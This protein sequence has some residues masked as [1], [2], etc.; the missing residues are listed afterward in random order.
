MWISV[1]T[2]LLYSHLHFL[3][4]TLV[5]L[6]LSDNMIKDQGAEYLAIAFRNNTVN[7]SISFVSWFFPHRRLLSSTLQEI[8]LVIKAYKICLLLFE[9]TRLISLSPFF[10]VLILT[11]SHRRSPIWAS[12]VIESNN[13]GLN[14]WLLLLEIIKWIRF[15]SILL[16]C[17]E[18]F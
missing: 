14:I 9:I 7:L 1:F 5:T 2:H 11:F 10:L 17:I 18:S 8:K 12:M 16:F 15:L 3:T 6:D 4:Q 13:K